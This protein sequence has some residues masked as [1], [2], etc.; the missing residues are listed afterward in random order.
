MVL[1]MQVIPE[2]RHQLQVGGKHQMY[3]SVSQTSTAFAA[4]TS[5]RLGSSCYSDYNKQE[6]GRVNAGHDIQC[7]Q[8]LHLYFGGMHAFDLHFDCGSQ[9]TEL[10]KLY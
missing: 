3:I 8:H 7:S 5:R 2:V 1:C 4:G 10:M 9:I 6:Q